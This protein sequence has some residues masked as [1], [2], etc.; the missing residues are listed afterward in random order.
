[1]AGAGCVRAPVV[2]RLLWLLVAL[3]ACRERGAGPADAAPPPAPD[4]PPAGPE[5]VRIDDMA[6]VAPL[7]PKEAG[8]PPQ[9]AVVARPVW[10]GL[11]PAPTFAPQ[12]ALPPPP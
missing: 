3:A 12:G 11:T 7:W 5:V 8:P 1:A 2:T 10:E 6:V 9:G 4:A